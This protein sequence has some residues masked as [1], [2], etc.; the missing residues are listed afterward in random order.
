LLPG[1]HRVLAVGAELGDHVGG[2]L[3]EASDPSA[4]SCHVAGVDDALDGRERGVA[5]VVAEVVTEG[6]LFDDLAVER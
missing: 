1:G 6:H 2:G 5:A 3:V 4:S